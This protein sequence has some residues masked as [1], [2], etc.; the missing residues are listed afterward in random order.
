MWETSGC[1]DEVPL[2]ATEVSA[3]RR[4]GV[5]S[6]GFIASSSRV[7]ERP[8]ITTPNCE[9]KGTTVRQHLGNWLITS[10]NS[11]R[12]TTWER[13]EQIC[14]N[15]IVPEIGHLKL[16]NLTP[17]VIQNLYQRK[18]V[19]LSPRTVVYIHVTLYKALSQALNWNLIPKNVTDLV[20]P[21]RV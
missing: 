5:R 10:R 6:S 2:E 15:H 3:K 4:A 1:E 13:Y 20:N 17:M 9:D 18:L 12:T 14:R 21:P 8:S 19:V 11:V 16:K 7:N